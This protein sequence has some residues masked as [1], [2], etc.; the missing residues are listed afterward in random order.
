[1]KNFDLVNYLLASSKEDDPGKEFWDE[2]DKGLTMRI[3]SFNKQEQEAVNNAS[4]VNIDRIVSFFRKLIPVTSF[5]AVFCTISCMLLTSTH[6]KFANIDLPT[7]ADCCSISMLNNNDVGT[8]PVD[9]V[10]DIK[11]VANDNRVCFNF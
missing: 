9:C 4:K 7:C 2:F 11:S 1:M 6:N 8:M 10:L 3:D 5:S